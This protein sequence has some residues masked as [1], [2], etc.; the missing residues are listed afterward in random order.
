LLNK[1]RVVG[2]A[3][4]LVEWEMVKISTNFKSR[5]ELLRQM[6]IMVEEKKVCRW[7]ATM[8]SSYEEK[9]NSVN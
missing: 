8:P 9:L 7:I 2:A 5:E 6:R 3:G 4:A 1:I